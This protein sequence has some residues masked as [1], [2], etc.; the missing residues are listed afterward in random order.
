MDVECGLSLLSTWTWQ[1]R[2]GQVG[3]NKKNQLGKI[4]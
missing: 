2:K 1:N 4:A 3:E